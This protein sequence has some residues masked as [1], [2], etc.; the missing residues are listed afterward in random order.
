MKRILVVLEAGSRSPSGVVRA[1]VYRELFAAHGFSAEFLVR[2][3]IQLMEGINNLPS[4]LR[5]IIS[6]PWLKSRVLRWRTTASERRILK[7][8]GEVTLYTCRKCFRI[9]LFEHCAA[10]RT[11]GLFMILVTLCGWRTGIKM[12]S[13]AF[14]GAST[15]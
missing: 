9:H 2:Q 7:A 10:K 15:Q 14:S 4:V 13:M 5:L 11:P 6:R 3:P 1:L 12:N 8:A